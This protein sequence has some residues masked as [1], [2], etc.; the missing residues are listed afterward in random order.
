MSKPAFGHACNSVTNQFISL[1]AA[2]Q[3]VAMKSLRIVVGC[4]LA[5]KFLTLI[6]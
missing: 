6:T 2:F 3:F 4:C 5:T 1:F